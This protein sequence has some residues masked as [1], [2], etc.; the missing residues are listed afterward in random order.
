MLVGCC[1]AKDF[2][3]Q[4]QVFVIIEDD[5]LQVIISKLNHLNQN[6][7]LQEHQRY[8]QNKVKERIIEPVANNLPETVKSREFFYDPSI[9]VHED[10]IDHKGNIFKHKGE[11][12]NPL[13]TYSFKEPWLFF[14][15]QSPKQKQFA[16]NR[17]KNQKLKLILTRGKPLELMQELNQVVYFDQFGWLSKKFNITQV[18]AIVE[19]QGKRLKITEIEL[20]SC[21]SNN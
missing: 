10:L 14:N 18:P 15:L 16:L 17:L 13:D 21:P 1:A 3:Q 2:G 4:G 11:K 20:D 9:T 6:G 5:L 12:I 8:I 7:E 19:Q